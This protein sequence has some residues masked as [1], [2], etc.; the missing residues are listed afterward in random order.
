MT[1]MTQC[2]QIFLNVGYQVRPKLFMGN[3][4]ILS[5]TATLTSP[6]VSSKHLLTKL[7]IGMRF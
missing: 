6:A 3:F 7:P 4:E 2:D 5:T 1:G